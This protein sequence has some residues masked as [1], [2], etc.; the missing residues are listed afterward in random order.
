MQ[1]FLKRKRP[2][3]SV[4]RSVFQAALAVVE[5]LEDRTLLAVKVDFEL[6]S[7]FALHPGTDVNVSSTNARDEAEV[8]LAIDPRNPKHM[9]VVSTVGERTNP[10]GM[11]GNSDRL[12]AAW[13]SDAGKTWTPSGTSGIIADTNTP[14]P[15]ACCDPSAAYDDYGTLYVAYQTNSTTGH[16]A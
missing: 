2:D 3:F 15:M 7:E 12:F 1:R 6:S 8:A 5:M 13:S 11:N 9:F 4:R 10:P 16:T 14:I